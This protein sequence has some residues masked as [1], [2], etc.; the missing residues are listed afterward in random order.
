MNCN[1]VT[2]SF[3]CVKIGVERRPVLDEMDDVVQLEDLHAH[4]PLFFAVRRQAA[5][6]ARPCLITVTPCDSASN[7]YACRPSAVGPA[8]YTDTTRSLPGNTGDANRP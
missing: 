5:N 7:A 3:W 1:C 4:T 8:S 6:S 2:V